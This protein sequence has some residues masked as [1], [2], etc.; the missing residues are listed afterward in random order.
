MATTDVTR[1]PM[2]PHEGNAIP[3]GSYVCYFFPYITIG[4]RKNAEIYSGT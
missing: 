3:G 4:C 1:N 2:H